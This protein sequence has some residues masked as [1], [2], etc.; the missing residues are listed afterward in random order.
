MPIPSAP[1]SAFPTPRRTWALGPGTVAD[2]RASV[3]A[4]AARRAELRRYR[5][6]MGTWLSSYVW[7]HYATLTDDWG[8]S[9]A[10]LLREGQRFIRRLDSKARRRV[11][12]FIIVEGANRGFPHLHALVLGT[13]SLTAR[14]IQRQWRLGWSC[15]RRFDPARGAADYVA[16]ELAYVDFDPDLYDFRFTQ[17][18]GARTRRG[19]SRSRRR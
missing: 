2:L 19:R 11:D 13:D 9:P 4:A 1:H 12:Y 18:P 17:V 5:D 6:A 16:K 14:E 8:N 7:R 10:S 15:V 3:E